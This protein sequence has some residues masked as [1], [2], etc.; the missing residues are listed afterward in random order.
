MIEVMETI[1]P[2][3]DILTEKAKKSWAAFEPN[4]PVAVNNP[5]KQDLEFR[6]PQCYK[7]YKVRSED[8]HSSRPQFE[9]HICH[10]Q[11]EFDF[12]P[13][14]LHAIFTRTLAL[15]QIAKLDKKMNHL[16]QVHKSNMDAPN[17]GVFKIK[18]A[19]AQKILIDKVVR[20]SV[21]NSV[22][23]QVKRE[24]NSVEFKT[25]PKCQALNPRSMKECYKCGVVLEK[26]ETARTG[27]FPSL[28][29]LWHDLMHDYSN[30]TRHMEFIDRCEE[31]HA[32]PFALKKYKELKEVQPQDGLAN[33]M[34]DS[35]L[36]KSFSKK[37]S[38][39]FKNKYF[40]F[41]KEIPYANLARVSP[42]ALALLGILIGSFSYSSRNFAGGGVALLVLI[43][44]FKVV[45]K[46]PRSW[47][48]L[49]KEFWR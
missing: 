23:I 27:A 30:I 40:H 37:A 38:G 8:I 6:C 1:E 17:S 20:S 35:V 46:N 29:K 15:P 10:A 41:L 16:E 42:L 9:C 44:G 31:M 5:L 7:L 4:N 45:G 19:K 26:A 3:K 28:L 47:Q 34:L 25:C 33:Q 22:Q 12:P 18:I 43:L 21:T 36:I 32:L 2:D 49:V 11:F 13:K 24:S 39:L 14:N 48:D